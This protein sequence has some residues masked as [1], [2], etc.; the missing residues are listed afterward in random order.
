MSLKRSV[1][2]RNDLIMLLG[3]LVAKI[4]ILM[5]RY[6]IFLSIPITIMKLNSTVI[7]EQNMLLSEQLRKT[8][9]F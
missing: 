9:H 1:K 8:I 3:Y 2:V 6:A 5:I 4:K 7:L